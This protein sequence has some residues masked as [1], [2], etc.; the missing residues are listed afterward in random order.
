M[1]G[2]VVLERICP[3]CISGLCTFVSAGFRLQVERDIDQQIVEAVRMGRIPRRFSRLRQ[4][5]G[6]SFFPVPGGAD[7]RLG[8]K[9]LYDKIRE[10]VQVDPDGCPLIWKKY[11]VEKGKS[12]RGRLTCICGCQASTDG[13]TNPDSSRRG[14]PAD[15]LGIH[16]SPEIHDVVHFTALR[17]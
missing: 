15:V 7:L 6:V 5:R 13:L 4:R 3:T 1:S 14:L 2:E 12:A 17:G 9:R 8:T 11:L 10:L 16:R